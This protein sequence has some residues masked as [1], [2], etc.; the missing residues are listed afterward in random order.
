MAS[1]EGARGDTRAARPVLHMGK[2]LGVL[3]L[4]AG[5]DPDSLIRVRGADAIRRV[6]DLAR[7]LSDVGWDMETE[8]KV[9]DT[10]ERRASLQRAVEQRGAEIAD[11]VVRDYYRTDMRSR[12]ARLRRPDAP[13]WR[14]GARRG[15]LGPGP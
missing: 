2:S 15:R 3:V 10:P 5:E 13:A 9:A 6:L 8:G 4:P 14:P 7:P 1:V 11:P 12:L